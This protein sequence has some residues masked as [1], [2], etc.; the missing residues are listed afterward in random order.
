MTGHI[1]AHQ[2]QVLRKDGHVIHVVTLSPKAYDVQL[3]KAYDQVIGRKTVDSLALQQDAEIAINGGFF[4]IGQQKDGM[5]SGN[6]IINGKIFFLCPTK[7]QTCLIKEQNHFRIESCQ[8]SVNLKIDTEIIPL[9]HINNP[10][11]GTTLVLYTD[12]WGSHTF[13]EF[14]NRKEIAF[15][16]EGKVFDFYAHGNNPIPRGGF[17]LSLPQSFK[18]DPSNLTKR[19]S[20][21]FDFPF[22]TSKEPISLV[23]GIPELI[24]DGKINGEIDKNK[25]EFYTHPHA[26]TA[27]G[28]KK[29]GD[30]V[31]IVAEHTYK[32]DLSR[33]TLGDIRELLQNNAAKILSSHK[34]SPYQLTLEELKTILKETF[35]DPKG[36]KGLTLPELARI[37]LEQGCEAAL[38]LDGGGS[39]TL[40]IKD[41]IVNQTMGDRD[42]GMG[43]VGARPISDAI[44]FKG[45]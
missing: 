7:K 37:M 40:W 26:R 43:R 36:S 1:H 30:I 10:Q 5:P 15:D 16:Q 29:N 33:T 32:I 3:I 18:L 25:G 21:M 4:E 34:K 39:S 44:V 20:L 23:R 31:I 14:K 17:I 9:H 28:F 27:I 11:N 35:S 38:N 13:T 8:G 6:L 12:A 45:K 2:Y 22:L 19:L 41:K 42:E 24:R